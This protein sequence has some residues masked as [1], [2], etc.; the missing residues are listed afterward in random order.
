MVSKRRLKRITDRIQEELSLI[1]L[2]E[3]MDPRLEGATITDV[4]VDP[5]VAFADIYV[6]SLEGPEQKEDIMEGFRH[7]KGF[8]RTELAQRISHLRSFPVLRFHWDELP[9]KVERINQII[10]E[11]EEEE[12]SQEDDDDQ[13]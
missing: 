10:A 1:I 11:L 9:Q 8:L 12:A 13:G 7:A 5:E 6:T 2:R 3:V 4:R